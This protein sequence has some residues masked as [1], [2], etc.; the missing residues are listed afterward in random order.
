MAAECKLFANVGI[1]A[2]KVKR[3][4]ARILAGWMLCDAGGVL[5]SRAFYLH[6]VRNLGVKRDQE[7]HLL[8]GTQAW[9]GGGGHRSGLNAHRIGIAHCEQTHRHQASETY[10]YE[11]ESETYERS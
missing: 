1:S 3:T 5:R 11:R 7:Q 9:G 2:R 4:T 10:I 6:L 8:S